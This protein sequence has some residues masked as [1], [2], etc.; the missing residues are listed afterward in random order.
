M[1]IESVPELKRGWLEVDA[2]WLAQLFSCRAT[3][4][5]RVVLGKI[6]VEIESP[7]LKAGEILEGH[8]LM[9][10]VPTGVKP[11]ERAH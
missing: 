3:G 5:A 11:K 9:A 10:I 6:Q 2:R 7:E 4:E 1:P 8:F